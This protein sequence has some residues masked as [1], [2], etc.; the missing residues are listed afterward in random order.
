[1][2]AAMAMGQAAGTAAAMAVKDQKT[3]RDIDVSVLRQRLKQ[4]GAILD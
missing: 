2:P 4:N 3:V 1:M